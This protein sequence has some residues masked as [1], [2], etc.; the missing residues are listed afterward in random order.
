MWCDL[1]ELIVLYFQSQYRKLFFSRMWYPSWSQ[2][3]EKQIEKERYPSTISPLRISWCSFSGLWGIFICNVLDWCIF[4]SA[5]QVYWRT[6]IGGAIHYREFISCCWPLSLLK[7]ANA[8]YKL[9]LCRLDSC[10][11]SIT[12]SQF[13]GATCSEIFVT[14]LSFARIRPLGACWKAWDPGNWLAVYSVA[15]K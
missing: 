12:Y 1:G 13:F 11:C 14:P 6:V 3:I 10:M 5:L 4:V 2:S 8:M 7:G 9:A 15:G